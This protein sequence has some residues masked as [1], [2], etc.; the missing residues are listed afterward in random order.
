MF[1]HAGPFYV[2]G[3][4]GL[5]EVLCSLVFQGFISIWKFCSGFTCPECVRMQ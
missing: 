1:F 4:L 2:K 3:K 5:E